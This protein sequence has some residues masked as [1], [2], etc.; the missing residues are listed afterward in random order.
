METWLP[1]HTPND[2]KKLSQVNW[3][4]QTDSEQTDREAMFSLHD[5]VDDFVA[6]ISSQ[7]EGLG[8]MA[9]GIVKIYLG[10]LF[11]ANR[12]SSQSVCSR[13][14]G[15]RSVC[16]DQLSWTRKEY[17]QC[18]RFDQVNHKPYNCTIKSVTIRTIV[19]SPNLHFYNRKLK[20]I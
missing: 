20:I 19:H 13:S 7:S 3:P 4:Q 10:S 1:E 11:S 17:I 16:C 2:S 8:K 18:I 9:L 6:V 5:F 12:R 15:S 14:V